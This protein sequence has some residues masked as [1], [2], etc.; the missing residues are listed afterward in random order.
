LEQME[1][2]EQESTP[3]LHFRNQIFYLVRQPHEKKIHETLCVYV[4]LCYNVSRQGDLPRR[5]AVTSIV[6]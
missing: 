5:R 6:N 2:M 3:K 4:K 1:Q